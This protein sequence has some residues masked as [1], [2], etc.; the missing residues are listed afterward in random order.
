M[1]PPPPNARPDTPRGRTV[2]QIEVTVDRQG[3]AV[4]ITVDPWEANVAP[5]TSI[6]W[7]VSGADSILIEPKNPGRWP[8]PGRPKPGN[9]NLPAKA[10]KVDKD[11]KDKDRYPY[12]IILIAGDL[13]IDIDP[14]IVIF[15][16]L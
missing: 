5:D 11:A 8:F 16:P 9:P 10:G 4:T 2:T 14:D 6:E 12:N 7:V 1:T 15:D 3:D 13:R